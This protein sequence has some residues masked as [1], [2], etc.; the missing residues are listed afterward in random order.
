[1]MRMLPAAAALAVVVSTGI[2]QGVWTNRWSRSREL[3]Q[4]ITRLDRVANRIGDWT[5]RDA[6]IDAQE[7]KA[8]GIDGHLLRR[9]ENSADGSAATILLVAG[10]PGPISVHTPEVCY[11]GAG[12]RPEAAPT[13][14]RPESGLPHPAEFWMGRFREGRSAAPMRLRILWAWGSRGTWSAPAEAR[15]AFA[16]RRS[17][18]KLYVISESAP[19]DD[20]PDAAA[21]AF[22]H[23]LM[24][25]LQRALFSGF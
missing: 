12:Y 23:E 8:A 19:G 4:A 13:R 17:L 14:Y 15:L 20:R 16:P 5:G 3:D 18:Y 21:D 24:P 1:M 7:L 9:Y 10:R 6:P 22:V 2:A 25:E 11:A